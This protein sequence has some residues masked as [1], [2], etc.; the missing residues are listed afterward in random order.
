MLT[1]P[2]NLSPAIGGGVFSGVTSNV[3]AEE[4]ASYGG[5]R[6]RS[7]GGLLHGI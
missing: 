4:L 6:N 3:V 5:E 2:G 7:Q 1:R